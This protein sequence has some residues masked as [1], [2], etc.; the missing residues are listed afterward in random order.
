MRL[1]RR[2]QTLLYL[3]ST[4]ITTLLAISSLVIGVTNRSGLTSSLTLFPLALYFF[5]R[6]L[7]QLRS[8]QLYYA[9]HPEQPRLKAYSISL[10][11]TLYIIA[12][13][14]T[15]LRTYTTLVIAAGTTP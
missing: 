11:I 6:T 10:S 13:G 1:S 2:S 8:N 14:V 7:R 9:S 12:L 3:Y 15:L 4:L 5:Y